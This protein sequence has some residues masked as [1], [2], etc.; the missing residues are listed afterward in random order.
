MDQEDT[1]RWWQSSSVWGGIVALSATAATAFGYQ[2]SAA[3]Q[4]A[5][6]LAIGQGVAAA[7]ALAA[8][9]GRLIA[10]RRIGR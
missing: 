8:L 9:I 5:A 4:A 3:D 6:V 7:G 10:T 2:V 1:K